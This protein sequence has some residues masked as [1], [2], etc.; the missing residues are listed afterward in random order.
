METEEAEPLN[1]KIVC[2]LG[3]GTNA[4]VKKVEFNNK[5][6]AAKIFYR[7]SRKDREFKS[8]VKILKQIS[9]PNIIEIFAYGICIDHDLETNCIIMEYADFGSLHNVL[10]ESNY[11]YSINHAI[12]WLMQCSDGINYLHCLK[13]KPNIHRDLKPLNLLLM[14]GGKLLKICDFGTACDIHTIMT[15]DKG[16]PCWMAP[17]ILI[18][19]NYDEKCDVYSYTI[20]AWEVLARLTP[21][22]NIPQANKYAILMGVS[23]QGLRP[24]PIQKCPRV[25]KLILD[26]GMDGDPKKRPSMQKIF[27]IMLYLNKLFNTEELEPLGEHSETLNLKE[28]HSESTSGVSTMI[29]TEFHYNSSFLRTDSRNSLLNNDNQNFLSPAFNR[30]SQARYSA[31]TFE[32]KKPLSGHKRSISYGHD[33]KINEKLTEKEKLLNELYNRVE[34]LIYDPIEPVPNDQLSNE[35]YQEHLWFLGTILKAK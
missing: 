31:H 4:Q 35:I 15:E 25:L 2:F 20:T 22:F 21:Y 1:F 10:H 6:R 30:Q 8:E 11:E 28:I 9:H 26:R 19:N 7:D 12:S 27:D 34:T 17:E 16:S 29:K 18:G 13:P 14:N 33:F 5:I 32:H 24:C 3:S 23:M